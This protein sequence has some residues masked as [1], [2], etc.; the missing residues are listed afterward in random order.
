M[1]QAARAELAELCRDVA[2]RRLVGPLASGN[3][4]LRVGELLLVTP[5]AVPFAETKAEQLVLIDAD[6]GEPVSDD[7]PGGKRAGE[8]RQRPTT[9]LALHLALHAASSDVVTCVLHLHAPWIVAASCLEVAELPLLHYHQ[10]LLGERATPIAPY[11]TPGSERLAGLV[12]DLLESGSRAV[13][14]ANHGA[15]VLGES[16]RAALAAG[17]VLED[18]CRLAVLTSTR[19]REL[20]A[21][22]LAD[23]R[24]LFDGYRP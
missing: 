21:Q 5:S 9:E 4:S 3:A 16:I 19:A 18:V 11:A 6:S 23:A 13:L 1:S 2:S 24:S 15:V 7:G 12:A 20:T 8:R 14:M 22:D 10:A 17:E